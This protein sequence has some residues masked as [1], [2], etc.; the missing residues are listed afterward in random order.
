MKFPFKFQIYEDKEVIHDLI[1]WFSLWYIIMYL[2]V[3]PQGVMMILM[4]TWFNFGTLCYKDIRHHLISI[5]CNMDYLKNLNICLL[6]CIPKGSQREHL[7]FLME[8]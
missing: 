1:F 6:K 8:K 5:K 4:T 2:K 7:A 3:F